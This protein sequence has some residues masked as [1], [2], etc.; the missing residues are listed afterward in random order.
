MSKSW[1]PEFLVQGEWCSNA[2]RFATSA[3]AWESAHTRF[4]V[5]TMPSDYRVS[6]SDDPVNYHVVDG[7]DTPLPSAEDRADARFERSDD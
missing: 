1:K 3:E 4:L 7:R 6:E 2:Q 5:W